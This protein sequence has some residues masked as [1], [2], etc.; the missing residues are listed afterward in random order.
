VAQTP[1]PARLQTLLSGLLW[2]SA[3]LLAA[4][5]FHYH[6]ALVRLPIPLDAFEGT[7]P[8]LTNLI[9]GG[10]NP[11]VAEHQPL[12]TTAYPT[13]YN[14][15]VSL[16]SGQGDAGFAVHRAVSGVCILLA[17]ALAAR[18]LHRSGAPPVFVASG[19]A[20]LYGAFLFY[21]TPLAAP[22]ALGLL[23]FLASAWWPWLHR[24]SGLSLLVS[25][26]CV[27]G[28]FF[29]KQYFALGLPLVAAYLLLFVDW[30]RG[31]A[32]GLATGLGLALS[33][34]LVHLGSPLFIDNTILALGSIVYAIDN[35]QSVYSQ[36]REFLLYSSGLILFG[37]ALAWR[38]RG[39]GRSTARSSTHRGLMRFSIDYNAWCLCC[40]TLVILFVLGRNPGN[41]LT[42]LF[43]LMSPFLVALCLAPAARDL[44]SALLLSP[45]LWWAGSNAWQ[46]LPTDLDYDPAP[47]ARAAE[48]IAGHEHILNSTVLV[49]ALQQQDRRVYHGGLSSMYPFAAG[50]AGRWLFGGDHDQAIGA[51]W[52]DYTGG[53]NRMIEQQA[54]DLVMMKPQE[55]RFWLSVPE[56][57]Q[58][59]VP[60][61]PPGLLRKHYR[62]QETLSLSL[63]DRLGGGVHDVEV[64]VPR[65]GLR[66]SA[67]SDSPSGNGSR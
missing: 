19:A 20:L 30:R 51:A 13:L 46:R 4:L 58:G 64:W 45:L 28:G 34:W 62:L 35:P 63:T 23:L 52:N 3:A 6:Q 38:T 17:C 57:P 21:S 16:V 56:I 9:A 27:L 36:F 43:Q 48:L 33:L 24:F 53:I 67:T 37:A 39:R 40:T 65:Q 47:W 50:G 11:F 61:A 5:L 32:Y 66:A 55:Y 14:H 41:Y 31:L 42:Y 7:M 1:S 44:R 10:G 59:P 60:L 2:L 29:S 54:F 12:Y 26:L 49:N 18:V 25:G 8:L 15:L 22:N